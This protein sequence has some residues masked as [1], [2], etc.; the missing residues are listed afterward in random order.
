MSTV[1]EEVVALPATQSLSRWKSACGVGAAVAL[2]LL[3][4]ASGV[5]KLTDL[6]A[7]AERMIQSLVPVVLS[8]PAAVG[9]AIC[10]TFAGILLLIPRYRRWGAWIAG[11]MLVAF[12][13]YIGVL[14]N[15]LLG[16]DC[17]CFPWIQRVV[18]PAFFVGDAAM[19]ALAGLAAWGSRNSHGWRQAA[20]IFG[21]VC[22]LA[23]ASFGLSMVRRA[24]SG[25]PETV[26]VD[27]RPL[28]LRQERVLLY[29]FDPECTHCLAVAQEMGRRDWG[30]T[31][32][33][34]LATRE[35]RFAAEFL[36]QAGLRAGISPDA[37]LLRKTIAFTDPP[38]AVALTRGKVVARFNSGQMESEAYYVE[39]K[40]LGHLKK[41][42]Q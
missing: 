41:D 39:L 34:A 14:Y 4:L 9:V 6:D 25:V 36:R 16:E 3:F 42:C 37:E 38:F 1:H 10:E 17:N 7:T 35:Q 15:R 2:S 18:G 33:V 28:N 23:C 30:S 21:G 8:M 22:L 27:G 31:A 24:Q 5:W 40:R 20:A 13:I 11:L 29:F 32:V 19:L 12:M 26:T